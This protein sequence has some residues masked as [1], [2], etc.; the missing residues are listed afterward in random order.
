MKHRILAQEELNENVPPVEEPVDQTV[1]LNPD[2]ERIVEG[3]EIENTLGNL[4]AQVTDES[5]APQLETVATALEHFK[6]RLGDGSLR[7]LA[8]ESSDTSVTAKDLKENIRK[9][10]QALRKSLNKSMEGFFGNLKNSFQRGTTSKQT[11][12]ERSL[13]HL[14][15]IKKGTGD[16]ITIG[17]EPWADVFTEFA[18]QALNGGNIEKTAHHLGERAE[19]LN[20]IV[21]KAVT[22]LASATALS[23]RSDGSPNAEHTAAMEIYKFGLEVD[24]IE[25]DLVKFLANGSSVRKSIE[26]LSSKEADSFEK[27]LRS[28]VGWCDAL[29]NTFYVKFN[30]LV[31]DSGYDVNED[32]TFEVNDKDELEYESTPK[33]GR[34]AL[35][36]LA[37]RLYNQL[38]W[39][40]GTYNAQYDRTLWGVLKYLEVSAR[41]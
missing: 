38:Q 11:M 25:R 34:M 3:K 21:A 15:E 18:G 39:I 7:Q 40:G 41:H 17:H 20:A 30:N 36:Y 22:I 24:E 1:S 32:V 35:D 12:Y 28:M 4:E 23:K 27:T 13:A 19:K 14:Q 26:T 31:G 8:S 6:Q 37:S 2:Y 29:L 33:A 10:R 9:T 16:T 5:T